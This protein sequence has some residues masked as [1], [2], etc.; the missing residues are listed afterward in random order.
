M[1]Q[2]KSRQEVEDKLALIKKMSNDEL[3]GCMSDA[4]YRYQHCKRVMDIESASK[5]HEDYGMYREE[6][7]L[8]MR[9][10]VRNFGLEQL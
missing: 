6:A 2:F 10:V 9:R 4:Y 1:S 5:W 3:I 8:R 7:L